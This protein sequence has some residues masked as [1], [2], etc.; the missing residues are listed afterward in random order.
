MVN[1][2]EEYLKCR[3]IG[4]FKSVTHNSMSLIMEKYSVRKMIE[5]G[6][7]KSRAAKQLLRRYDYLIDEYWGVDFFLE[8]EWSKGRGLYQKEWDELYGWACYFMTFFKS[9]KVLKMSSKEASTHFHKRTEFPR[10]V[11]FDMVYIDAA[12]TYDDVKEDIGLWIDLIKPG[13]VI[14]GH[15]YGQWRHPEVESAVNDVLGKENIQTLPGWVW[16]YEV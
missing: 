9:F 2:K 13:G 10:W 11:P 16:Y 14:S 5:I 8:Q 7:Y 3:K 15:D 12:H 6:L 4:N 1:I